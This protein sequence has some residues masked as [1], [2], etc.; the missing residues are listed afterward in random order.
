M[1]P[2]NS[3]KAI[4]ALALARWIIAIISPVGFVLVKIIDVHTKVGGSKS[5][6]NTWIRVLNSIS[7]YAFNFLVVGLNGA[8]SSS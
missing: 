4:K 3:H 2:S 5:G 8:H 6:R 1:I 7:I